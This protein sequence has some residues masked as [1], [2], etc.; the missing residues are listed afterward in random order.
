MFLMACLL[1]YW[2]AAHGETATPVPAATWATHRPIGTQVSEAPEPAPY[3]N[4]KGSKPLN[5]TLDL[6]KHGRAPLFP[7]PI[8]LQPNEA[9]HGTW[10]HGSAAASFEAA[11]HRNYALTDHISALLH[12]PSLQPLSVMHI[13]SQ[14]GRR[15]DPIK[16]SQTFHKGVDLAARE[17]AQ[18]FACLEGT[19]IEAGRDKE[20]G[21]VVVIDHHDGY[22]TLYAHNS[23]LLVHPGDT[24]E[25]GQAIARAGSTGRAT[26]SHLHFEVH[27]HG[28]SIDPM[29]FLASL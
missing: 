2:Q 29:A 19:V 20:Y 28:K 11:A 22:M 10:T 6:T 23:E 17:G 14:F 26:G 25:A 4:D 7:R 18:V 1:A 27:R 12:A 21:N 13:T 24:V 9:N 5:L 15:K 16:G 8:A 3:P